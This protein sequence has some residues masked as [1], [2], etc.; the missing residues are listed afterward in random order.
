M[1]LFGFLKKNMKPEHIAGPKPAPYPESKEKTESV[2]TTETFK[3]KP[4]DGPGLKKRLI[5]WDIHWSDDK[6]TPYFDEALLSVKQNDD[7]SVLYWGCS[8]LHELLRIPS[9]GFRKRIS[10][11][12]A[13]ENA[14]AQVVRLHLDAIRYSQPDPK[15]Y[16]ITLSNL[17]ALTGR[18]MKKEI[19]NAKQYNAAWIELM[20]KV[21]RYPTSM[22]LSERQKFEKDIFAICG[23]LNSCSAVGRLVE[24]TVQLMQAVERAQQNGN[25]IFFATVDL[26]TGE[27]ET[28]NTPDLQD[29]ERIGI[30]MIAALPKAALQQCLDDKDFSFDPDSRE[31]NYD[32]MLKRGASI[33]G[34]L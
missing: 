14:C 27:R 5:E 8:T 33:A 3:V 16:D 21:G 19:E 29:A 13:V 12:A 32:L 22:T 9:N 34:L 23:N 11:I 7:P 24:A 15:M 31:G 17:K 20:G 25:S 10:E 4:L 26:K 30:Y 6:L 18:S 2:T 1:G 28:S